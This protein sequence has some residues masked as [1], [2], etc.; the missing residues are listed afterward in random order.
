MSHCP[1]CHTLLEHIKDCVAECMVC[2][3]CNWLEVVD[4]QQE[5]ITLKVPREKITGHA[6]EQPG[7]A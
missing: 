5:G 3:I 7:K 6:G 4:F 1:R 2:P